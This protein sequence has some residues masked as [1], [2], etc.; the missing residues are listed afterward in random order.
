MPILNVPGRLRVETALGASSC[1]DLR[2][3]RN[4]VDIDSNFAP[5]WVFGD[6]NP[7]GVDFRGPLAAS[8]PETKLIM[9]LQLAWQPHVFIDV[10]SNNNVA[11]SY[12][13]WSS[14]TDVTNHDALASVMHAVRDGSP[15]LC[16]HTAAVEGTNECPVVAAASKAMRPPYKADGTALDWF[17]GADVTHS[18][19]FSTFS[20]SEQPDSVAAP[21]GL[22]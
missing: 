19:L 9:A 3:N 15:G 5:N 17:Y 2:K 21:A 4:L 13:Q 7:N 8:E 1:G 16:N 20:G 14:F 10:Q 6:D 12:A 11:L 18:F 22:A